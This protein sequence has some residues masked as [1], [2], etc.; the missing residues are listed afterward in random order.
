MNESLSCPACALLCRVPEG[1]VDGM[2]A[3][4]RCAATLWHRKPASSQRT[5]AFLIAAAVLYVPA[6]ALP[7]MRITLL[8]HSRPDTILSGVVELFQSGM[9]EIGALV[10][11][12]S[13]TVPLLKIVTLAY[14]LITVGRRAPQR[15]KE[16]TRMYRM[17]EYIG[18]WSMIDMFMLS[19]LVALVQLGWLA[20]IHPGPGATCFAGVVILTMFAASSFDPRLIWDNRGGE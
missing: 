12:A 3:C 4:P 19:I 10:F 6:N 1:A 7:V 9:W 13:I 2:L 8:G 11:V 5:W 20:T 18:R 17:V 15:A 16:R 14:L